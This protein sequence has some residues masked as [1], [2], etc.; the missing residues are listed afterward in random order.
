MTEEKENKKTKRPTAIK[1]DLQHEKRRL[2]NKSFKSKVR[3]STRSFEE[4]FE[5]K[6]KATAQVA[7]NEFFSLVDKGLKKG[8]Y[9]ANKVN[10]LKSQAS[11][12]VKALSA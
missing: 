3:T 1:R 5:G 11:A 7:L 8:I 9:K 12:K 10:R 4:A 2:G 6:N